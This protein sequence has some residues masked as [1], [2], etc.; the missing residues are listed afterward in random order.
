MP[1][2]QEMFPKL[3]GPKYATPLEFNMG[4]YHIIIAENA[5][6]LWIIILS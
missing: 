4:Y 5:R 1:K 3:E 2:I 6:N